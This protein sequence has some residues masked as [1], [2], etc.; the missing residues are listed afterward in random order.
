MGMQD[1]K[2]FDGSVQR[3]VRVPVEL[4]RLYKTAFEIAPT[5]ILQL[6]NNY[7]LS[8]IRDLAQLVNA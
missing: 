3:I 5:W 4:K 2:Y 7:G 6:T 8:Q 1:L